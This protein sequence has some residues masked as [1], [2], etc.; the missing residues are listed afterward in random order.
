MLEETFSKLG[1][2][3]KDYQIFKALYITGASPASTIAKKCK[4]ER[5]SVYRRLKYLNEIGLVSTSNRK[6]AQIFFIED[7][8][9]LAKFIRKKQEVLNQLEENYELIS[10]ELK[11]LKPTRTEV[12]KIKIYENNQKQVFEKIIQETKRQNISTIR[13]LASNTVNEQMGGIKLENIGA[14]FLRDLE[15]SQIN[16]E[17]CLAEG[18]LT[19]ERINNI[20]GLKDIYS[21]PAT[22]GAS[23][24][25]IVGDTVFIVIFRE[26]ILA[27]EINHSD[28]AQNLHFIF[29]QLQAAGE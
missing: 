21:L 8:K 28:I 11:A 18:M 19:R 22:N 15:K 2:T 17:T 5:T 20:R 7:E 24:I 16:I 13:L 27:L 29:D 3:K 1:L 14:K 6:G 10:N 4:H 25:Y 23:Q 26:T 9:D 12:P